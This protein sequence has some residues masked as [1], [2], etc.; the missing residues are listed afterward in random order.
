M[1]K[2][3]VELRQFDIEY[4]PRSYIKGQALADFI[5]E[6][7]LEREEDVAAL[8]LV[9]KDHVQVNNEQTLYVWWKMKIDGAVNKE[10]VG[11]SI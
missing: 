9:M 4:K 7:L 3:V 2:W 6:F 8:V 5:L 11:V 1:L 10:G